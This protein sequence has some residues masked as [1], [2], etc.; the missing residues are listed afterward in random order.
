MFTDPQYL[1]NMVRREEVGLLKSGWVM[2][3]FFKGEEALPNRQNAPADTFWSVEEV[4]SMG[5]D[6]LIIISVSYCWISKDH[7]DPE[8][9][10]YHLETIAN[11][12]KILMTSSKAQADRAYET[13]REQTAFVS[14]LTAR[15]ALFGAGDGTA[16]GMF[17]D[18]TSL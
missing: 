3:R 13:M 18:W 2:D 5:E 14:E 12:L 16:V 4:D 6:G 15:G 9:R 1:L 8:P 17:L 7:P 10:R 11:L